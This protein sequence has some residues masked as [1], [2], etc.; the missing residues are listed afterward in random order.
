[1]NPLSP[2]NPATPWRVFRIVFAKEMRELIRD[3]KTLF[4]LLAPPI[5]LPAIALIA[6]LFVGTQTARYITQ[7]FPIAVINGSAAPGLV[8][9]LRHSG[10]LIVT[11]LPAGADDSA[12]LITLRVPDDFQQRLDADQPVRLEL[13]RHDNAFVTTLALGAVRSEIGV[14][15]DVVLDQRLKASGRDADHG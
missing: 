11:E 1:M 4:W 2:K 15:N 10:T 14:Y 13:T 3:R 7:G 8:A 12:A 5:I 9:H 6:V